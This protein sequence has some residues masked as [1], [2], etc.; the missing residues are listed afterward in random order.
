[1]YLLKNL[2]MTVIITVALILSLSALM[3]PLGFNRVSAATAGSVNMVYYGDH[4][5][6][7]DAAIIAAH[8]E[9]LVG[10]SPSNPWQGSADISKFTGAGIKYLEYIWGG[11]EGKYPSEF[12]TSD[13][14]ANLDFIRVAAAGGAYGIFVDAVSEGVWVMPDYNYLQQ[15]SSL[16]RSL[17]LLVVFNTGQPVWTDQ[18]MDYCD[19][20][21]STEQWANALLTES[22]RKWAS[23]TW[24][25]RYDVNDV[26]TAVNLTLGAWAQ[27]L[28]AAYVTESYYAFPT[29]LGEYFTQ[30]SSQAAPAPVVTPNPPASSVVGSVIGVVAG[31]PVPSGGPGEYNLSFSI[32]ATDVPG[33]SAGQTV[34][35]A[36]TVADFPNL[37]SVGATLSGILDGT[38]GWWILRDSTL[39]AP[40]P[41]DPPAVGE[42]NI[43]GTVTGVPVSSGGQGEY[44]FSL[45]ITA[46]TVSGLG[47]GQTIWVAANTA[48]FP[49][50]LNP[51]AAVSGNLDGSLGWWVL[52]G[53]SSV[54][55]P[56]AGNTTA[57]VAS[58]PVPS[59]GANQYNLSLTIVS[60]SVPGLTPGQLV[61]VAATTTDFP[62]LLT[63]GSTITGNLDASFGWWMMSSA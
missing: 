18:L 13:L 63:V 16:A 25:L 36:A 37:L 2:R 22:Q 4:S 29:W 27:G 43:S 44:S 55:T 12:V 1:M 17:D 57:I 8:P 45:L 34:W 42:G 41:P 21:G 11:Y 19:Y 48:D 39:P 38:L 9:Y 49:N 56:P 30:L 35:V 3:L 6:A 14:Q 47:N 60:T 53:L 24:V 61:W 46:T 32:A 28:A 20:I 33:L 59:G 50:L 62:Q 52:R 26:D 54:P 10:N 40:P 31:V 15:I 51:G 23:R 5:D 58:A 7:I